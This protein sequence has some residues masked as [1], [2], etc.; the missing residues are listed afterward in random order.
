MNLPPEPGRV[1]SDSAAPST[2]WAGVD[3]RPGAA[4]PMTVGQ[5]AA[6]T[7][8]PNT[9][10]AP[11][12]S[13]TA[14]ATATTTT[15]ARQVW[16]GK[17]LQLVWFDPES[18][19][20]IHRKEEL[21]PILRELENRPP[22]TELDDPSLARDPVAVEDRRD[23]FEVLARGASLDEPRL[24]Q[25]LEAA[26]RDDGKFTPPLAIVDG[27]VRF[28]FDELETLRATL[29]IAAVFAPCDEPL[30]AAI[31]DAREFLRTPDLRS[32]PIV[33][34]GYTTRVQ[35][36]LKRAKRGVPP[37]YLEEQTE[38]VLVEARHYQRRNVYGSTHLRALMQIGNAPR[39]WPVY[40]PE[41]AAGKLPMFARF[42]ARILA[43]IGFQE[44]Q[45][46]AHPTALRALAIARL[47]AVSTRSER[48]S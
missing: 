39:L 9:P 28:L 46:E 10:A 41:S 8:S 4:V 25:A 19:P 43:E 27:E 48:D 22:D 36:A 38:R 29:T 30:R 45:Y 7:A 24:N 15:T 40:V 47:S 17:A 6:L 11:P 35:E 14:K 16:A 21:Q 37:G 13:D 26:V 44:S 5:A 2:P 1:S 23:V 32:P 20:R 34:E 33:T 31:A 18:V 12:S 3:A 42:S